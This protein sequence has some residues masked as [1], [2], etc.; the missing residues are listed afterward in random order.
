MG[1]QGFFFFF[2]WRKHKGGALKISH[3]A[4]C[5]QSTPATRRP[6]GTAAL[7]GLEEGGCGRHQ[8][9]VEALRLTG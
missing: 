3:L 7:G 6:Q 8:E 9:P 1:V 4:L 2:S 5:H